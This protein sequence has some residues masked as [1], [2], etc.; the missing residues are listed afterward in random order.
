MDRKRDFIPYGKQSIDQS[1]IDAVVEVLRGDLLTT[2]PIV[3][4]FEKALADKV[5][6]SNAVACSN[7]TTALHLAMIAAGIG[8]GD[9]VIVPS[10][11]FLAT[12]N[13]VRYVGAEVVFSDV[14]SDT[15]LMSVENAESAYLKASGSGKNVKAIISVHLG[16]QCA[17]PE[18]LYKFANTNGLVLIEDACHA[19]GTTYRVDSSELY[20]VGAC[21]HS[22][23]T[24]FSFHP[25][26]T[27][28]TG[29]GG[30]VTCKSHEMA[31]VMRTARSHGMI[32]KP[33][34]WL[35]K[36]AGIDED[37]TPNSWYYEMHEL[38]FNFRLT[39]FQCALGINQLK[40]LSSFVSKR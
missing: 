6:A 34:A 29:E 25:V 4:M 40:K 11:T 19:L 31:N 3:D 30:A 27:L 32:R 18:A 1:D 23:F 36:T 22:D 38:G 15:G 39:D 8:P 14:D 20:Q 37:G 24:T 33:E 2:G 10:I 26:K 28:T 21:I 13:V 9:C 12:A 7:G 17:D 16:G 35:N 5:G